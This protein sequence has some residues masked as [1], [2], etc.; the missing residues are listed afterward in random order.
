VLPFKNY[1]NIAVIGADEDFELQSTTN[2]KSCPASKGKCTFHF[3]TDVALGDRGSSRVNA[4]PAQSIGPFAGIQAVGAMHGATNVT[5]GTTAADAASAD[6]VVVVVGLTPGDEGEEYALKSG[7]DRK[8]LEL[9]AN[10]AQ[11]VTDVL[12]LGKPTVIIV[13]SGSIVNL[14][15]LKSTTNP[16]QATIWAGYPGMHGGKALARLIF[17]DQ[18]AN[19]S[20]KMPMA[21]PQESML[22]PFTE[23]S[24]ATTMGYFFGYRYY[25]FKQMSDQLVYP[26]GRGLSYTTFSYDSVHTPCQQVGSK[27]II[28]VT[29]H[30]TNT[31]AMAGDEVVLLFVKGPVA[32][33]DVSGSARPVKMLAS[34]AK[35]HLEP[36]MGADVTLPV[37]VQDLKHWQG[38]ANG[39]WV[40]DPGTYTVLVGPSGADKDLTLMDTFTV[41]G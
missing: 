31:G 21:W 34:F 23:T 3:A 13:E 38:D 30:V 26:F 12:A 40:V 17:N 19:F 14:P 22:Q 1:A 29:A 16:N 7:G 10:Q 39:K 24:T 35:Q 6:A 36:G 18:G 37:R 32:P 5:S 25:D 11:L 28:N 9:P 27:A 8:T 20:G 4:D 33:S 2:P 41:Q 15:W